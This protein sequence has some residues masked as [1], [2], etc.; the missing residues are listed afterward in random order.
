VLQSV[1][2]SANC[3]DNDANLGARHRVPGHGVTVSDD[4]IQK[5]LFLKNYPFWGYVEILQYAHNETTA[6]N[7]MCV[8]ADVVNHRLSTKTMFI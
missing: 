5:G 7:W 8:L 3:L 2:P 1:N 6:S 4:M